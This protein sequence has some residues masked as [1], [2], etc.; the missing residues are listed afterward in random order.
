MGDK[1]KFLS[2]KTTNFLK[3]AIQSLLAIFRTV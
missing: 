1:G 2:D 3:G